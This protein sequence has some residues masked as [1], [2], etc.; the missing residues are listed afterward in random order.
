MPPV[1]FRALGLFAGSFPTPGAF[2]QTGRP[3]PSRLSMPQ[4]TVFTLVLEREDPLGVLTSTAPVVQRAAHVSLDPEAVLRFVANHPRTA[5][6]ALPA[7]PEEALHCT[8]LPPLR[9]LNYLLAL[10]A[11]NFCFWDAPPRWE[12]PWAGERH[13]GYWALT[14]ALRRAI[15]D[16]ALPL[17]DAHWLAGLGMEGARRLL[18]GEGRPI[19]LLEA[20]VSHLNEVG[21]VLLE[22]WEGQFANLVADCAGDAPRL[23]LAIAEAFPSFRDEARW[24]GQTVRFHKRAQI[25]VADLARL[26]PDHPLGRLDGLERLTAF[27]DYKVP[28]VL[29]AHGMLRLSAHLA[30]RVDAGE[31]IPAASEAEIELRAATVWGCEW[32][33]R[34][35]NAALDSPTTAAAEASSTNPGEA[36]I[37]AAGVDGMLWAAGQDNTGLPPYHRTRTV[38]Y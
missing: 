26:L 37:T 8:F 16:D 27:A 31:E 13:D 22:R 10:E 20:R 5:P 23:A 4:P 7:L 33:A 11:L 3:A 1:R 21:R 32:L 12:V 9:R 38:Y 29:R 35:Y 36:P 19:P 17:W 2:S 28:Q 34:A 6:P 18:R 30:A 25:C 15:R 14:A 24:R